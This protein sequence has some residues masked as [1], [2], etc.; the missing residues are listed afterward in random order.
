MGVECNLRVL[1][2]TH[3]RTQ[4]GGGGRRGAQKMASGWLVVRTMSGKAEPVHCAH[5]GLDLHLTGLAKICQDVMRMTLGPL[6]T[7]LDGW[8]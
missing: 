6:D 8:G 5:A 4:T 2:V 3:A 7:V 1:S